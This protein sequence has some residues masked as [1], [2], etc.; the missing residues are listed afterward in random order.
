MN[1]TISDLLGVRVFNAANGILN[2]A[3]DF[4]GPALCLQLGVTSRLA[5]RLLDYAFL[6]ASPIRRPDP[7]P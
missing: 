2:L 7:S 5:D 3:L 6:L 4:I 1:R